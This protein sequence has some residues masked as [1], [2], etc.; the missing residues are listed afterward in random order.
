MW[1][2][3]C[4]DPSST[5]ALGA[6]LGASA[7]P[8]TVVALRGDLGAGKTCFGQGVGDGLGITDDIVSPTFILIAEYEGRLPLLHADVYRLEPGESE[9]IGLEESLESWPGLALVEWAERFPEVLPA[10]HLTVRIDIEDEARRLTIQASG[11]RSVAAL[12]RWRAAHGG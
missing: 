9:G 1:Q 3:V 6:A 7:P 12:A 11:P 8:G 5:Q 10:D 4:R 2:V